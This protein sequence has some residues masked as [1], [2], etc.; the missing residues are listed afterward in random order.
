MKMLVLYL[1][2]SI[3]VLCIAMSSCRQPLQQPDD[4]PIYTFP[5]QEN[6]P[7]T[8]PEP[9]TPV[10]PSP[11]ESDED[12]IVRNVVVDRQNSVFSIGIPAGQREETEVT[13]QTP[14]DFWFEYLPAEAKLEVNGE[15]VPRDPF[16]RETKIQYTTSVTKFEYR[17]YNTTGEYISYNLHLVPSVSGETVPVI[18]RQRWIP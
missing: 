5:P 7:D 3:V 15:E 6:Q 12:Y 8:G 13:A 18:V 4:V 1:F 11:Q 10:I 2:L 14:V 16:H 17:I 9:E